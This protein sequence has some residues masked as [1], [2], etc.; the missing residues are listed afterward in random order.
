MSSFLRKCQTSRTDSSLNYEPSAAVEGTPEL[1]S[2][3]CAFALANDLLCELSN[4]QE[5]IS[6]SEG[7]IP[8]DLQDFQ[9]VFYLSLGIRFIYLFAVLCLRR[10]C[11]IYTSVGKHSM[12]H[13]FRNFNHP[14][15]SDCL[16]AY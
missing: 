5:A 1:R 6:K 7:S 10:E 16:Q 12:N 15:L 11:G 9:L 14:V 4:L 2:I 8:D 3:F 13:L